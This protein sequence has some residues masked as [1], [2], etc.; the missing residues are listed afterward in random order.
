M[1]LALTGSQLSIKYLVN[2]GAW[3]KQYEAFYPEKKN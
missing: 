2:I 3:E 1:N